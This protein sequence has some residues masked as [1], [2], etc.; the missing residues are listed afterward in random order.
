MPFGNP[1][2]V[3]FYVALLPTVIDIAEITLQIALPFS[4][5]IVVVWTAVLAGYAV[6]AERAGHLLNSERGRRWLNR[7]A[8]G[9]IAGAAGTIAVRQ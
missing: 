2:A 7:C 5:V 8:A 6:C 9:T 4:L 3:G 1:K